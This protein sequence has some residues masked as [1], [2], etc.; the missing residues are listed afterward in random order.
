[1]ASVAVNPKIL[2]NISEIDKQIS[3]Q[4]LRSNEVTYIGTK[5]EENIDNR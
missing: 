4:Y 2:L 1:M 5:L 3:T